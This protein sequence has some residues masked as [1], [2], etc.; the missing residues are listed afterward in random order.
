LA[1]HVVSV[2]YNQL[3]ASI[4]LLKPLLIHLFDSIYHAADNGLAT[5]FIFLD[6]SAAF[7]TIDHTILLN[8]CTSSFGIMG[9]SHSWLK[10]YLSNMSFSVTSDSSFSFILLPSCGVP[11]GSVM[12]PILFTIYVSPIASILSSHGVNQQ[13][14]ADDT[15]LF[16]FLSPSSLSRS[17]CSLQRCASSLHNWFIHN[18]LVLNPTK[19]RQ[20]ALA[21][22]HNFN[23]FP[24]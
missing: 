7:D 8:R 11:Q 18:G 12:G 6:L 14:Y 17:L 5:L 3:I 13:Q 16:V 19:L 23:R 2:I 21:P 20:F 15:Q 4:T 9:S 24:I 22:A 10:S 1:A